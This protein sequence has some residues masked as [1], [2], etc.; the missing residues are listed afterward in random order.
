M[1]VSRDVNFLE[2]QL[3]KNSFLVTEL[4]GEE[5]F[6]SQQKQITTEIVQDEED[7]DL[8]EFFEF[9]QSIV[10]IGNLLQ[11]FVLLCIEESNL[12]VGLACSYCTS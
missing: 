5:E 6:S 11:D 2:N 4:S 7:E 12:N 10:D 9:V 1:V 8:G 3:L